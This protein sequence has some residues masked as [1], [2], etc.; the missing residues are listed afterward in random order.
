[1]NRFLSAFLAAC[2]IVATVRA[3]GPDRAAT[4]VPPGCYQ[5]DPVQRTHKLIFSNEPA[6]ASQSSE[7]RSPA[8]PAESPA[9]PRERRPTSAKAKGLVEKNPKLVRSLID[10]L[11]AYPC[12]IDDDLAFLGLDLDKARWAVHFAALTNL[13]SAAVPDL[14]KAA[15]DSDPKIA[16]AAL[17]VLAFDYDH[18]NDFPTEEVLSSL[19]EA[20]ET[21]ANRARPNIQFM[22]SIM[23]LQEVE[24]VLTADVSG[25]A[26]KV[27]LAALRD[28]QSPPMPGPVAPQ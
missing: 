11:A 1:M 26:L 7:E 9:K 28:Q 25:E 8:E 4:V 3:D 6:A 19:V 17:A 16:T 2:A 27:L 14:L 20:S 22:V 21:D 23:I 13:G 5:V 10:S 12:I 24:G 18:Y 15:R